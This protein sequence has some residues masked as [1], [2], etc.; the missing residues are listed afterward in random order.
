MSTPPGEFV[1]LD[2]FAGQRED[3]SDQTSNTPANLGGLGGA[4]SGGADLSVSYAAGT[5]NPAALAEL[6]GLLRLARR[7]G[8]AVRVDD[9]SSDTRSDLDALALPRW[10]GTGFDAVES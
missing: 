6:V 4:V 8:T 10:V 1:A 7:S 3:P 9:V 2:G 5:P